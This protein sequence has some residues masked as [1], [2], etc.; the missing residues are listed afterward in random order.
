MTLVG[1]ILTLLIL[2]LSVVFMTLAMMTFVTH[3]NWKE[4]VTNTDPSGGKKLGLKKQ[5]EN[6][7]VLLKNSKDEYER[8]KNSYALEQAARRQALAALQTAKTQLEDQVRTQQ[9]ELDE[10]LAAL[11]KTVQTAK[12]AQERLSTLEAETVKLRKDLQLAQQDRD[13]WFNRS[14]DLTQKL[15][16]AI[17]LGDR[18]KDRNTQLV[19]QIA[20]LR[21]VVAVH[22]ID[23]DAPVNA[24]KTQG[25]INGVILTVNDKSLVEISIGKDDG[26]RVE[27]ELD[28]YRG[29]SY[30]G[31]IKI[32][33]TAPDRAVGQIDKT[34]QR[35]QMKVGDNVTSKLD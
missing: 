13:E 35:G 21:E 33:K 31:R 1:K 25:K 34:I 3:K 24:S 26:I 15:N 20:K 18:V 32:V 11:A 4:M 29:S 6:S 5:L 16:E 12:T 27:N 23:P 30:L 19:A 9:K 10:K 7:E 14:V 28:V 17:F 2:I 22:G 8:L